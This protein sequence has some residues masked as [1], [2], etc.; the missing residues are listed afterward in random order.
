MKAD[1]EIDS[2]PNNSQY[3]EIFRIKGIVPDIWFSKTEWSDIDGVAKKDQ[4][5]ISK[6]SQKRVRSTNDVPVNTKSK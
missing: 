5:F 4:K 2:T 3:S 6:R 1:V